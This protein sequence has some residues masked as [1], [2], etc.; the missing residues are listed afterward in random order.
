MAVESNCAPAP[1]SNWYIGLFWSTA[2]IT[3]PSR[4]AV[5]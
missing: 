4:G 3:V 2:A 5:A 1:P